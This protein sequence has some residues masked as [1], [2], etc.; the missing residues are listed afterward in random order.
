MK[1]NLS[2]NIGIF[3]LFLGL[4]AT[5]QATIPNFSKVDN[6]V[7]RGGRPSASDLK[8]LADKGMKT[9]LS[10]EVPNTVKKERKIVEGLGMRYISVPMTAYKAPS[11]QDMDDIIGYLKDPSLQP[12][13][14]HCLHGEDRSGLVIGIYR[15][16]INNWDP[17]DAYKE[18]LKEGFHE[19]Y[20]A[21]VDF[22]E[23]RTGYHP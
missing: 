20:Q 12:I 15:T 18:M 6:G 22:F 10:L 7:Y 23:K 9:V 5:A 3:S 2:L 11:N 19:K 21:L 4:A 13:F 1:R 17:K 14:V 16:E 8:N